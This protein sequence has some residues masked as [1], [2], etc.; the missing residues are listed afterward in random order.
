MHV[1]GTRQQFP[2][3]NVTLIYQTFTSIALKTRETGF[4][5]K[6]INLRLEVLPLKPLNMVL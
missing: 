4:F 1:V 3:A 6:A 5:K 2:N